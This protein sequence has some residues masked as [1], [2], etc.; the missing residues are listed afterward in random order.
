MYITLET[1]REGYVPD[2]CGNTMTV[3]ELIQYL[4]QFDEDAKVFYSN[5]NGYTYG[6]VRRYDIYDDCYIGP[7]SRDGSKLTFEGR[8]AKLFIEKV[9]H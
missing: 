7:Y 4:S 8:F 1:C 2:Q 9:Y 6:P 5:D 3:G